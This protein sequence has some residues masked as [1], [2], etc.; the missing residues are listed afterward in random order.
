M[1]SKTIRNIPF[2]RSDVTDNDINSAA[3]RVKSALTDPFQLVSKHEQEFS[4][5]AKFS[6]TV[7]VDT[8]LSAIALSLKALGVKQGDEVIAP[9]Y[10]VPEIGEAVEHSGASMVFADIDPVTLNLSVASA[11]AKISHKTKA[12][13]LFDTAG[14]C[15]DVDAVMK[16]ASSNGIYVIH[17]TYCSIAQQYNREPAGSK[18]HIVIFFNNEPFIGGANISTNMENTVSL[19]RSLGGHGIKPANKGQPG[20][21]DGDNW[22]YEIV[23]PGFDCMMTGIQAA[24]HSVYANNAGRYLEGRRRIAKLYNSLLQPMKDMILL[25]FPGAS[26]VS[27]AWQLYIVRLIKGALGTSRD[28]FIKELGYNGIKASVHYIP[29]NIHPYYSKKYRYTYNTLPN[30]Y[31]AYTSAVSLPLYASLSED[32]A[33]YVAQTVADIVKRYSL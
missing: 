31:E 6:Y 4:K 24:L 10:T 13:I 12:V 20:G 33:R 16:M 26:D 19:I 15:A 25:P 9:A 5:L 11:E 30:T 3:D 1:S 14:L 21:A 27:H 32:D 2:F 29:L 28:E 22:Y 17:C 23:S 7:S 18:P 8:L